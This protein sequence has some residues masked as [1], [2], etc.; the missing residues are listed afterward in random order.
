MNI[1]LGQVAGA[2]A[3]AGALALGL[4]GCSAYV[5]KAD[6]ESKISEFYQRQ[7]NSAP[8][9]TTCPDNLPAE[10]GKSITCTVVGDGTTY[11]VKVTTTSVEGESVNFDME[12]Q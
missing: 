2:V 12:V 9:S 6:V 4:G 1:R 10:V 11:N 8:T 5:E 7:T 3:L